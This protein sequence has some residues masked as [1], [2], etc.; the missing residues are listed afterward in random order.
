MDYRTEKPALRDGPASYGL[1]SRVN[2]W[3]IAAGMIGMIATGLFLA[4]GP[5]NPQE[6]GPIRDWHK[7]VGVVVLAYGL[8]R[9]GWR[10]AQGFPKTAAAMP[11]WQEAA[12]RVAHWGLLGS[13]LV[14][15][16]S[17]IVMSV[18]GGRAVN[19]F[20]LVIPAQ[21]RVE[22]IAG[23]AGLVHHY[24]AWLLVGLLAL[25]I[26]AAL[27]HHVID[28]DTTLRRMVHGTA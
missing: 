11:T 1:V 23:A 19:A 16:V 10:L 14:M 22:W 8:W 13:I 7:A 20:G 3:L 28:R 12:S 5:M 18:Y 27:K 21:Q 26:G 15:P 24:A 4:Y 2:H 25:H 6:L 17:G 9:V